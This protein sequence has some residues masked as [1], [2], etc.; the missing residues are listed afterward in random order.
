MERIVESLTTGVFEKTA[1][2]AIDNDKLDIAEDP[3]GLYK[4]FI[5]SEMK[6][7]ASDQRD[8]I[9]SKAKLFGTK[10]LPPDSSNS[11]RSWTISLQLWQPIQRKHEPSKLPA[12]YST[13]SIINAPSQPGKP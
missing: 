7:A 8:Y 13:L 9:K 12:P 3:H 6:Q 11:N 1:T 10:K 5:R 2:V 4:D